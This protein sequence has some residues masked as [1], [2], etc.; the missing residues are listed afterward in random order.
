MYRLP[1]ILSLFAAIIFIRVSAQQRSPSAYSFRIKKVGQG[2]PMILI[3]GYKGSADTYNDVI[4]HFKDHYTCY[5]VTLAGFAGQPP[6]GATDN[7]L[8]KQRDDLIRFINDEHL[9]H[10]V[11]VGFSFGGGLALWV[12]TTVPGQM[13]PVIDIDGT[14]FDADLMATNFNKDSLVQ[15]TAI[16]YAK[17]LS[18]T[19]DYWKIRDSIFHSDSSKRAGDAWIKKLLT[20]TAR[21]EDSWLWDKASDFRTGMLMTLEEDTLDLREAVSGILTPI[22]V[23]G[24]WVSWDYPNKEAALKDYQR[25]WSN[26]KNTTIVFSEHGKHFLMYEDL[27]WMEGQM[28]AFLNNAAH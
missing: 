24:S 15:A 19:P 16:R 23:L 21:I 4:A 26:A 9:D 25:V 28:E 3:P 20:D 13:G 1:A 27:G 22:L 12:A 2:K 5:V 14:P 11:I 10:P 7:L 8:Q 18:R 6:S 17:A